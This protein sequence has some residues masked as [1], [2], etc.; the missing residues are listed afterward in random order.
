ML[1]VSMSETEH[2]VKV[3]LDGSMDH[4]NHIVHILWC[5]CIRLHPSTCPEFVTSEKL[6]AAEVSM[7]GSNKSA[8]LGG[9][10]GGTVL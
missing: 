5:S 8:M 3:L 2:S 6:G 10:E 7:D 9:V 1:I 4:I